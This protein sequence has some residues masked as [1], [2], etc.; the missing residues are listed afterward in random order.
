M[1]LDFGRLHVDL[2]LLD[3]ES[4]LAPLG[5]DEDI[6]RFISAKKNEPEWMLDWRLK[7]YRHWLTMTPPKWA[8]VQFPA[9]DF[10]D[11]V[12]YSAP[13]SKKDGPKSLDEVDPELL[14]VYEKLGIPLKEQAVLVSGES[15]PLLWVLLFLSFTRIKTVF[16]LRMQRC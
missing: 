5:L 6:I 10:Q 2:E 1:F 3:I 12:Y 4:D 15:S 8:A 7:A 13:K 11:I 14:A 16:L 9:I